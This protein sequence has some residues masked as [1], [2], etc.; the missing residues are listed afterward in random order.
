MP[1]DYSFDITM[2]ILDSY[3]FVLSDVK[4]FRGLWT[5]HMDHVNIPAHICAKI[6]SN[7]L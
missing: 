6:V 5:G 2:Q 1:L 7:L 3:V 4:Q